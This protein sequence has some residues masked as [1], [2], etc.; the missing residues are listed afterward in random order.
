MLW[1]DQSFEHNI[2]ICEIDNNK[3]TSNIFDKQNLK[4]IQI[5]WFYY[6]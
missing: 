6:T 3:Q 2:Q 1:A 4:K 5:S